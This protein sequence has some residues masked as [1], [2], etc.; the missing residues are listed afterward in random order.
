M[1]ERSD[2]TP[3]VDADNAARI[4]AWHE[5][6]YRQAQAEAADGPQTFSYLGRTLVVPPRVHPIN[7]TSHLLGEAVLAEVRPGDRVLDMGTGCGVNAILA[8][9]VSTDVLA[10]DLNPEAVAAAQANAARNGVADRIQVRLGDV[11]SAVDGRFDLIVFDPP[12]RWFAPR[13][14]LE[15]ASTDENYAAM[16]RFFRQAREHLTPTGRMLIFFGS[17]GDIGHLRNLIGETGFDTEVVASTDL[18]KDDWR[19]EYFTFRLTQ[20]QRSPRGT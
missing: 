18:V 3:T 7:G 14:L 11:F 9:A 20:P 15:M 1:T 10:V 4:R 19:V 2:F 17:S 5:N 12:F 16:T 8:A 6:A 13:D